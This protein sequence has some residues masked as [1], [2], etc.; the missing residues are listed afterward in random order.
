MK[1][2]YSLSEMKCIG[3]VSGWSIF[4]QAHT[5]VLVCVQTPKEMEEAVFA[6]L[7]TKI[8]E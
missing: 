6:V 8:P 5:S 3:T 1:K 4:V 7:L 2:S